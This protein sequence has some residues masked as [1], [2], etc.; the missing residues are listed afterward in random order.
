[1]LASSGITH[2]PVTI[3]NWPPLSC[4]NSNATSRVKQ[5]KHSY[6]YKIIQRKWIFDYYLNCRERYEEMIDHRSF[7]QKI[8]SCER[9]RE[10]FR[11]GGEVASWLVRSTPE[12]AVQVRALAKDIVLCYW[13]RHFTLTVPLST[14]VYKWV[15]VNCW[16]KPNKL[17]GSDLWW[18][19]ILSRESKNT[20]SCFMLQKPG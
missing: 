9:G 13:A 16:G 1:M 3:S 18:T 10:P 8:S 14:Q 11:V 6:D 20:S 15:P 4:L 5:V 7:I 17:Q 19:S 12:W 2:P